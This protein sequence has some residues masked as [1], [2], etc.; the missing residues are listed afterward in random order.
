MP[1]YKRSLKKGI[2]FYFRGSYLGELYHSK[3]IYHTKQ[4]S[5]RASSLVP[6]QASLL[7][8][9]FCAVYCQQNRNLTGVLA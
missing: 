8:V 7:D 9:S 2:R 4:E 5:K 3:A 6:R 1:I